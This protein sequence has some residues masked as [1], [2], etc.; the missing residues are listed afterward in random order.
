MLAGMKSWLLAAIT[1]VLMVHSVF[2]QATPPAL[3]A[4]DEV[5]AVMRKTCDYQFVEQAKTPFNNG[6]IRSAFYTGVLAMYDASKDA[7]YLDAAEKWG[8]E[9]KWTPVSTSKHP[10]LR[11]ADNQACTQVY[12]DLYLL[13]P[14]EKKIA[15]ARKM[16]D[17][18][19]ADPK[20]GRVDW[21]WCDSLYMT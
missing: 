2:A 8:E 6:W 11:F 15:P 14:D 17:E 10:E 5:L 19:I 4:R 9:G 7:K 20:P 1:S 12:A 21:W 13:E 18:Q 16:F 3:P